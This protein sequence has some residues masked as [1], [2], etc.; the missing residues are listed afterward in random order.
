MSAAGVTSEPE[1]SFNRR[2]GQALRLT[3]RARES[4]E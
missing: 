4:V 2:L 3:N 1:V